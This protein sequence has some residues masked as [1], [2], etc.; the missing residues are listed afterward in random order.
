MYNSIYNIL[1]ATWFG[2]IRSALAMVG[3][4]LFLPLAGLA[5]VL[6]PVA[7]AGKILAGSDTMRISTASVAAALPLLFAYYVGCIKAFGTRLAKILGWIQV[8]AN[9]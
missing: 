3:L 7:A 4:V 2:L 1:G 5:T 9:L 6:L 8:K